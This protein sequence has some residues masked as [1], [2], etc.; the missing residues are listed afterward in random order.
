MSNIFGQLRRRLAILAPV[1]TPDGAGGLVRD[2]I[3]QETVWGAVEPLRAAFG[4]TAD[5]AGQT[6]THKVTL[7]AGPV[8]S[9]QHRLRDGTRTYAVRSFDTADPEARF[10]VVL[11]E[12]MTG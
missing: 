10:L 2:F 5:A 6:L 11:T 7:R 12:E 8:L 4:L 1:E 3:E 9:V